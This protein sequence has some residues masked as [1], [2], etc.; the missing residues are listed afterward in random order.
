MGPLDL[1][2]LDQQLLRLQLVVEHV[3]DLH[4]EHGF[5]ERIAGGRRAP[6]RIDLRLV[7]VDPLLQARD[8]AVR[9]RGEPRERLGAE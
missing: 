9:I 1:L 3:P 6:D 2:R 4:G 8:L 7:V 5:P